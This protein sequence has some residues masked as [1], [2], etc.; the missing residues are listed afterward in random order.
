MEKR[1]NQ[2]NLP[3]TDFFVI[4]DSNFGWK[5]DKFVLT[6]ISTQIPDSS[7][8]MVIGPVGSGKS[9][10]CKALLGEIPFS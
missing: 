10:F 1:S 9:T 4:R 8:T 7:L 5:E 2:I 3:P 6:R